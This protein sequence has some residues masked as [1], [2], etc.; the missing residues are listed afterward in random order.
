MGVKIAVHSA[1]V[2]L[3]WPEGNDSQWSTCWEVSV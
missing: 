1:H 3:P 2:H